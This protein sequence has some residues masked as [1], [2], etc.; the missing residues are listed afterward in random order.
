MWSRRVTV[1]VQRRNAYAYTSESFGAMAMRF[2]VLSALVAVPAY[3][4]SRGLRYAQKQRELP[5]HLIQGLLMRP[6][7]D[8]EIDTQIRMAYL[9]QGRRP[10]GFELPAS[11]L[12]NTQ[13]ER[14]SEV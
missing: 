7:T 12:P 4:A 13:I 10:P 1:H 8:E 6:P 11:S 2:A 3:M 5:P 9:M 14:H